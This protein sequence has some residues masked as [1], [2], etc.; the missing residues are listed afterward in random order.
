MIMMRNPEKSLQL[1]TTGWPLQ[2]GW[3][4][5]TP[6]LLEMTYGVEETVVLPHT[7]SPTV[8][9]V[10]PRHQGRHLRD[11]ADNQAEAGHRGG[12]HRLQ[13][14]DGARGSLVLVGGCSQCKHVCSSV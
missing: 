11:A 5:A 9:E 7:P 10:R 13:C 1:Y 6:P 4:L 12:I 2:G 14:G 8:A 3:V